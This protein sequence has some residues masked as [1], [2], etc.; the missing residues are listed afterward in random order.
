[1]R[2][3]IVLP[4]LS[5]L[6]C[7][8]SAAPTD[9][10]NAGSSGSVATSDATTG[11]SATSAA[12]PVGSTGG[13]TTGAADSGSTG[14]PP[15][16]TCMDDSDCVLVDNC[17]ACG[18]NLGGNGAPGSHGPG[19]VLGE[20][21]AAFDIPPACEVTQCEQWG[22]PT[23]ECRFDQ[24]VLSKLHCAQ[25]GCDGVPPQC[26]PPLV[27]LVDA[28]ADCWSGECGPESA[29]DYVQDCLACEA[30]G[31]LCVQFE[32][33]PLPT[34][35]QAPPDCDGSAECDCAGAA[36]CGEASCTVDAGAIVCGA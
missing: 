33:E 21:P 14:A 7:G 20:G 13:D 35:E 29:C 18:A 3:S 25:P 24:C 26:D 4:L 32:G 16:E 31:L 22:D 15:L 1:M 28:A 36:F 2:C 27:P 34:C 17:N 12:T 8:D 30:A 9:G 5:T 19:A 23:A 10:G 11:D 6:A